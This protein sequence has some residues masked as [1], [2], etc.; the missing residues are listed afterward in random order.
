MTA[1]DFPAEVRGVVLAAAAARHYPRKVAG[2]PARISDPALPEAERLYY[3]KLAFFA[4]GHDP[5]PWLTGWY[6]K[7]QQMQRDGGD[8]QGVKESDWWSAGS[9]PML[10]LIPD[11]DPFKPK[12][13]WNELHDEFGDRVT[14]VVI[15]DASHALF[16]EQP[17]A[18]ADAIIAW[19]RQLPP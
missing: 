13:H 2:A 18:V 11:H 3:L 12:R 4:P 19:A 16:P 17:A 10:E 7:T 9:A 5:T 8:K 1:V 14:T 6:P 15:A